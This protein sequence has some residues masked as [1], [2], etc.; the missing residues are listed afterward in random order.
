MSGDVP[1]VAVCLQIDRIGI[2]KD[3]RQSLRDGG[4]LGIGEAGVDGDGHD[5]LP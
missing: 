3:L 2:G 4:P 1:V 5:R